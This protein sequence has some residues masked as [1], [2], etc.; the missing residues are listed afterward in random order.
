MMRRM[1]GT[2]SG[3]VRRVGTVESGHVRA[4][5]LDMDGTIIHA[6]A[7]IVRS[8]NETLERMGY[9]P[10]GFDELVRMNG[11]SLVDILG[12][13]VEEE[14]LEE[15]LE[16]FREIQYSTFMQDTEVFP[17]AMETLE[18][19]RRAGISLGLFTMRRTDSADIVLSGLGLRHLFS[20]VVGYDGVSSPKPSGIHV[21]RV[22]MELA[23]SPSEAVAVGDSPQDIMAGRDAGVYTVGVLWGL[24]SEADLVEAGADEVASS[25]EE[26][27]DIV[28]RLSGKPLI[29][30]PVSSPAKW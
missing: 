3:H 30:K 24:A 10:L 8:I 4:V 9:R 15:A 6:V 27:K 21:L 2:E 16:V 1:D 18:E 20:S 17:G 22:L 29:R 13:Q 5:V 25:W 23:V 19:W 14:R 26:L 12:T 28:G 7:S 11:F